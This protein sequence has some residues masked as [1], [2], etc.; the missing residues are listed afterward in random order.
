[1]FTVGRKPPLSTP[2][3][4]VGVHRD[5]R[6][7]TDITAANPFRQFSWFA[8]SPFSFGHRAGPFNTTPAPCQSGRS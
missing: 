2:E 3:G 5:G 7:R 1:M 4:R 8:S 6:G